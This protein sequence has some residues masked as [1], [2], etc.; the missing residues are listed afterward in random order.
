MH[1]YLSVIKSHLP[2]HIEDIEQSTEHGL[3]TLVVKSE[4]IL[5]VLQFL[6]QH[7]LA[8]YQSLIEITAVDYPERAKRFDLLYFLLSY[9]HNSRLIVKIQVDELTVVDSVTKVYPAADWLEREVWDLFGIYFGD[10][11]DLRRIL[12]DYGFEGHPLRKDFPLTGYTEVRYDDLQKR[13]VSEPVEISQEFR[14]FDFQ[15]PWERITTSK[16]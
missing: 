13:V 8:K 12:T 2:E 15:S 16:K 1:E 10:H 4:N 6:K 9:E 14:V 7:T 5:N 3:P 11:P